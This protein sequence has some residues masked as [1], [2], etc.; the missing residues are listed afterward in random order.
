MAGITQIPA[1][2]ARVVPFWACIH[3]EFSRGLFITVDEGAVA[4]SAGS[5][6]LSALDVVMLGLLLT[7]L[8]LGMVRF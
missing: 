5:L 6:E 8:T 1:G 7:L 4:P 2:V 3:A